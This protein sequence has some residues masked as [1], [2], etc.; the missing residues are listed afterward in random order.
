[1]SRK[2]P[3]KI[4]LSV[5]LAVFIF[6]VFTPGCGLQVRDVFL[7]Q[8]TPPQIDKIVVLGFMQ[9]MSRGSEPGMIRS[10]LS[11]AVFMAQPVQE[12][13]P[14]ALTSKLFEKIRQSERYEIIGPDQAKG[15]FASI[16]SLDQDLSDR[17]AFEK[18]GRSFSADAVIV[19]YVYR[20]SE[21][22][23]TDYF[24]R[25]PSSVAFDLYLIQPEEGTIIWGAGFDKTQQSLSE[26]ILDVGTFLK[27][28]GRWMT[29]SELADVG[30][31]D[32]L[33]KS[34]LE[35]KEESE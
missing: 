20:W 23:G 30:L 24:V 4:Y 5:C 32:L 9:A 6:T 35:M 26:N 11:G 28:K 17:K 3:S 1:M 31:T 16:I 13:V 27:G 29:V 18:T 19:G 21:R 25:R 14:G 2:G 34:P 15:V 33:D 22:E 8:K 7:E 10:P 12:D